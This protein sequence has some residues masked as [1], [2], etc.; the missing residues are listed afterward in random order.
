M[1]FTEAAMEVLRLAGKPLHYRKITELAIA[2]NLLSHVGKTP[3]VTMSSRLATMVKKDRGEAPIVK[4]KPGIFGLRDFSP[5]ALSTAA[6]EG[7]DDDDVDTPRGEV[8]MRESSEDREEQDSEPR[9]A[10]RA[11]PGAEVF[12]AEEDDDQPILQNLD[13]GADSGR[14]RGRRRRRRRGRRD[15]Q[16]Q[17]VETGR[18]P[19]G[20]EPR[21]HARDGT[22]RDAREPRDHR[23]S[24]EPHRDHREHRDH[25]REHREPPMPARAQADGEMVGKSLADA[26]AQ[27]LAGGSNQPL[28]LVR[29]AE[30]LVRRGRLAGNPQALVPTIAAAVR[31]EDAPTGPGRGR[32][33]FWMRDGRLAL[34]DWLLP[35]EAVRAEQD[36]RSAVERQRDQARRGF[37]RT[38]AALP[39][40]GLVELVAS[41]LNAEGVSSLRAVRLPGSSNNDVHLAGT[42]RRGSEQV[43]LAIIVHRNSYDIKRERV[44]EVRGSLHHYGAASA[45]WIVTTGAVLSGAHEEAITAGLSP[46]VLFDGLELARA[47]ERHGIGLV[48]HTVKTVGYD[49]DLLEDLGA[50]LL[51]GS[52]DRDR[53]RDRGRDRD[54]HREG[55]FDRRPQSESGE[56]RQS[57]E[58]LEPQESHE[59]ERPQE[60]SAEMS[61]NGEAES[62]D[63]VDSQSELSPVDGHHS[64]NERKRDDEEATARYGDETLRDAEREA[65]TSDRAKADSDDPYRFRNERESGDSWRDS[66]EWAVPEGATAAAGTEQSENDGTKADEPT[67]EPDPA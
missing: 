32:P 10:Q 8:G 45:S 50:N 7:G 67:N 47:M 6:S 34:A 4:V 18:E 27:V 42:L 53:D 49:L 26:I 33:R 28:P 20:D 5:E 57:H 23:E 22:Q 1:T 14:G 56:A 44:V 65:R 37:A 3:E 16:G 48:E 38:I 24:R 63:S 11:L 13:N 17:G 43:A 29:V 55:R 62:R 15:E 54:R 30:F 61:G 40:A 39:T 19:R 59:Q 21:E 64:P 12:P 60:E 58:S 41:W 46:C 31:G 51:G 2:K 25:A 9:P 52:R 66:G 36:A 35:R